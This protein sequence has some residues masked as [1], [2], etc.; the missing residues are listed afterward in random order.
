MNSRDWKAKGKYL[1]INGHSV[2]VIDESTDGLNKSKNTKE[3][4]VILHGYPTSSFDYY[5]VLPALKEKYRVIIHDHIG[6]G[7]SDKPLD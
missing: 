4:L 7:F 1:Q 5:K 6:F 3:T 2:F